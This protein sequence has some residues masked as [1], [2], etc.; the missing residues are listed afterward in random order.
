VTKY[1]L[2]ELEAQNYNVLCINSLAATA[3]RYVPIM[4]S[5]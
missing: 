3:L 2:L 5:L 1:N 4:S